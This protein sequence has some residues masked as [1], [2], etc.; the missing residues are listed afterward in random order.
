MSPAPV[1]ESPISVMS[2]VVE[3]LLLRERLPGQNSEAP[4]RRLHGFEAARRFNGV[5]AKVLD[6]KSGIIG[7][8]VDRDHGAEFFAVSGS[9]DEHIVCAHRMADQHGGAQ[10]PTV[11]NLLE[12]RNV[13][14]RAV[15]PFLGPF[16]L[17]MAALIERENVKTRH[18]GRC[19]EVP[20]MRVCRTAVDEKHGRV[21]LATMVEAV[22]D[23]SV[24]SKTKFLH[25]A[26]SGYLQ[27]QARISMSLPE[28]LCNPL[29]S[30][31]DLVVDG[32]VQAS[33]PLEV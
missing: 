4:N 10:S 30:C 21:S 22:E 14:E 13:I 6:R 9:I 25:F 33:L 7:R 32:A 23:Q 26:Q 27:N 11:D 18:K 29:R 20:P 19:Y 1:F 17:P 16:T 24:S 8:S 5:G 12:V 2:Y 28:R 15:L 31:H 3:R